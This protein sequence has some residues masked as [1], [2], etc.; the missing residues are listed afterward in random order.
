MQAQYQDLTMTFMGVEVAR[1]PEGDS[2]G[3]SVCLFKDVGLFCIDGRSS[4]ETS[5]TGG[6]SVIRVFTS[7]II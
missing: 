7:F 6:Q 5:A 2:A 3:K 4:L 1:G